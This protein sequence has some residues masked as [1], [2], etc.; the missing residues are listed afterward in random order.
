M[1]VIRY[2]SYE[3]FYRTITVNLPCEDNK[4]YIMPQT[5]FKQ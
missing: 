2:K 1:F 5:N 3:G 4:E